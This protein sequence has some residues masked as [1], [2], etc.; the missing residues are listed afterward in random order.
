MMPELKSARVRT[1]DSWPRHN[2]KAKKR[3]LQRK[4]VAR[5]AQEKRDEAANRKL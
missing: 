1:A 2:K 3:H 4:R 5:E